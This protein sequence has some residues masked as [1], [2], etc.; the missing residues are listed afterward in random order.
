MTKPILTCD[1]VSLHFGG[2]AALKD[3]SFDLSAGEIV[4]LIGP[5]GAGKSSL[6]NCLTGFYV[7]QKGTISVSDRSLSGLDPRAVALLGVSRTF[8]QAES[9]AGMGAADVMLLGRD[10]FLPGGVFAY[11]VGWPSTRRGERAARAVVNDLGDELGIGED[12]RANTAYE[13]LPYGVRKLVDLGRALACEPD[14]LLMDEPA[15]G[16][17]AQ[18]K[19]VMSDVISRIRES[20]GIAQL[21]VD[22]DLGFVSA[23][24]DRLVVL[25]AG[26]VIAAGPNTTVLADPKVID[27][28]IGRVEPETAEAGTA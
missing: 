1:A 15:A 9:L 6:I 8:Q 14:I 7:P 11:A 23:L 25:D 21:L 5:N 16:L 2:V 12:V 24:A 13:N 26:A 17:T 22:H 19:D 10:R 20:R 27:S 28:Y 3:V 4:G 18:E